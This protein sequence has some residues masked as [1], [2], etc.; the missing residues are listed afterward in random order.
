MFRFSYSA[1][2]PQPLPPKYFGMLNPQ[3]L[4]PGPPDPL[5][6]FGIII[7]GG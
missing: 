3:P 7:V 4:P 6:Q 2:N 1:L 5:L